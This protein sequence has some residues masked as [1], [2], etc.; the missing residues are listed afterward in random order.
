MNAWFAPRITE[1]TDQRDGG[2]AREYCDGYVASGY[3][4][5]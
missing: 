4:K 5:A 1:Y 3:N 2:E